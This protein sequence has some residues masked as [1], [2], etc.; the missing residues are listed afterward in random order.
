MRLIERSYVFN[1]IFSLEIKNVLYFLTNVKISKLN[2]YIRN[3]IK[4][5]HGDRLYRS[6]VFNYIVYLK[7]RFY[8][9]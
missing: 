6:S 1:Y 3:K 2:F 9:V 8:F 7:N 4:I 5:Y